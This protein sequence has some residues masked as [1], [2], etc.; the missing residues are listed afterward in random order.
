MGYI[1]TFCEKQKTVAIEPCEQVF[2]CRVKFHDQWCWWKSFL[3]PHF[4]LIF[5]RKS[6]WF[7]INFVLLFQNVDYKQLELMIHDAISGA[8]ASFTLPSKGG[9]PDFTAQI[10]PEHVLAQSTPVSITGGTRSE[11]S[12]VSEELRSEF[13]SE[14]RLAA[15][16]T[17]ESCLQRVKRCNRNCVL[18]VGARWNRTF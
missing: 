18:L 15:S 13:F 8:I 10:R 14:P 16:C 6:N 11:N 1:S 5:Q 2:R 7:Q 17:L 4:D 9:Y 12:V 3:F